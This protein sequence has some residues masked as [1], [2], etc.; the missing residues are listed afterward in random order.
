MNFIE[1]CSISDSINT[2]SNNYH[3]RSKSSS[4]TNFN[5]KL[6]RRQLAKE[7]RKAKKNSNASNDNNEYDDDGNESIVN[8]SGSFIYSCHNLHVHGIKQRYSADVDGNDYN[9]RE[10]TNPLLLEE[11]VEFYNE[12]KR[13]MIYKDTYN[14]D[15]FLIGFFI[16]RNAIDNIDVIN[17]ARKYIDDNY[18][19]F[20]KQSKRQDDWRMHFQQNIYNIDN[21]SIEHLPI[22]NLLLQS[23][24]VTDKLRDIL[25][26]KLGGVFYSQVALR[27]PV[28]EGNRD[29]YYSPGAEYHI[30]GQANAS[31]DRFPDPWSV[32]IGIALV[33]IT[34][35]NMGN[36]TVFPKGHVSRSWSNYCDEKKNKTLPNL[37]APHKVC[38]RAGDVVFV[39]CLL[40]HMGGKNTY[41]L[42]PEEEQYDDGVVKNLPKKTR[43]MVFIRIKGQDIDYEATDRPANVISNPFHE[44]KYMLNKFKIA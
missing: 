2:D 5:D 37:G 44:F 25:G 11:A 4:N 21:R 13:I 17:N 33:D 43:E 39:H 32:Q 29:E 42:T 40:P 38:L 23:P 35:E 28:T 20:L 22:L 3:N 15:Y 27:T 8:T 36:F 26:C 10:I 18:N 9:N 6:L 12:G 24:K 34:T 30:D 41:E 7:R 19:K 31:G 1:V 14:Y 16:Q